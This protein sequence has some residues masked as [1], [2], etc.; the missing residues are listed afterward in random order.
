MSETVTQTPGRH[1][2]RSRVFRVRYLGP[3]NSRGSRIKVSD[4]A[5]IIS[6]PLI[7]SYDYAGPVGAA[8]QAAYALA[9][10]GW[11]VTDAT[12]EE[13]DLPGRDSLLILAE[14]TPRAR[15]NAPEESI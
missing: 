2:L 14:W 3:T 9:Q 8:Q 4:L 5:G 12:T 10:R 1:L 13:L 11:D 7:F 15:W 6:R